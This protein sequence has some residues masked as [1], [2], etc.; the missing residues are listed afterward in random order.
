MQP[1]EYV[2]V[3]SPVSSDD[4]AIV[5][6]R[7]EAVARFGAWLQE[8]DGKCPFVVALVDKAVAKYLKKPKSLE[9]WGA[10]IKHFMEPAVSCCVLCLDGW[11]DSGG[12]AF[13]I[14]KAKELGKPVFY[15][16]LD[17]DG[18]VQDNSIAD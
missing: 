12:L 8:E 4:L 6:Q 14:K 10:N 17:G 16:K 2:F 13:E 18:F 15:Y 9:W 3:A 5:E 7:M 11:R 1:A